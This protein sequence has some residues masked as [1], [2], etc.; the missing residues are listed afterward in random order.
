M[1]R[2]QIRRISWRPLALNCDC[3]FVAEGREPNGTHFEPQR[4]SAKNRKFLPVSNTAIAVRP[5]W[6]LAVGEGV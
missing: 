3:V 6:P 5:P 4:D 1:W 2:R